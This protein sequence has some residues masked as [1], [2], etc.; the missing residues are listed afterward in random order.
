MSEKTFL[1]IKEIL[2]KNKI[3]YETLEH[4]PV[5]TSEDAAKAR[6]VLLSVGVKA[7]IIKH[8]NGFI[9]ITL[10]AD[11][12][13][14]FDKVKEQVQ[15]KKIRFATLEEVK[16]IIDCERGGVPPFGFLFSI[17]TLMDKKINE[18]EKIEFNAGL[19]TKSIRM[20]SADYF[21]IANKFKETTIGEFAQ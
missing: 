17:R 16:E 19:T 9:M 21:M 12:K 18:N 5:I 20:N 1:A 13:I 7:M 6:G 14:N 15:T 2:D 8:D 4:E 11:K 10:P 3:V